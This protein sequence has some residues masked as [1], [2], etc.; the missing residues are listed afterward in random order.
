M[1]DRPAKPPKRLSEFDMIARYFAPLT[2]DLPSSLGHAFDLKDDAALLR[3]PKNKELVITKDALVADVHFFSSDDPSLVARKLIRVNL[4]DLAAKGATPLGYLLSLSLP[5]NIESAWVKAFAAGLKKDQKEFGF[6][7]LGGDTTATSGPISLVL[8]ALGLVRKGKMIRR[9]GAKAGDDIYLTGTLGD[10]VLGLSVARNEPSQL[11]LKDA[12]YLL[13]R[14]RLPQP[15]VAFGAKLSS[16]AN[17]AIDISDGL[18][19]DLGH[20]CEVSEVACVI[21]VEA[22]P[23]SKPARRA[24]TEDPAWAARLITGGDDYELLFTAPKN[25]RAALLRAAQ[26]TKT[27][28]TRIGGVERGRGCRFLLAGGKALRV[29]ASGYRHF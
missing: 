8:T 19:A 9:K 1:S 13:S 26:A 2:R 22:L 23:L 15:R 16:L 20:L 14:Y 10:A 5:H 4:S 17:A 12:A 27:P 29:E 18:K 21:E 24:L 28:L 3:V 11:A 6:H 7:L 25:Q